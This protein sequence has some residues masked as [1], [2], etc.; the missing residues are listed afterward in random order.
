[1]KRKLLV[2]TAM[3]LLLAATANGLYD[4]N[5]T[6]ND[7]NGDGDMSI[8]THSGSS[9]SATSAGG[10][11]AESEENGTLWRAQFSAE[12]RTQDTTKLNTVENVSF[13]DMADGKQKVQ[14]TGYIQAPTPCHTLGHTV[15]EEDDGYTLVMRAS[16]P[17]DT[18]RMCAQVVTTVKYSAWF[19]T[20]APYTLTVK[21]GNTT[22]EI[23]ESPQPADE[24]VEHPNEPNRLS[25]VDAILS[26]FN[27]LF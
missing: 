9:A 16:E 20:D 12:N 15:V 6:D 22:V 21:H 10:S 2:M 17:E 7:T 19:E 25:F 18:D 5:S 24:V 11:G 8:T 13:H 23:L 4:P 27:N 1:M 14:F 3:F 26:W